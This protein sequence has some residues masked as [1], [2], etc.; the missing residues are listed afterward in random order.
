[1][2]TKKSAQEIRI[3]Y[4]K[5]KKTR[6]P[7]SVV[8]MTLAACFLV[9]HE[10]APPV[11]PMRPFS[12]VFLLPV[13]VF[14]VWIFLVHRC[15]VCGIFWRTRRHTPAICPFCHTDFATGKTPD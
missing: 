13:P 4:E 11:Y 12:M 6:R 14:A 10:A 15:P 9:C 8:L 1:M 5:L 3:L 2:K 7:L